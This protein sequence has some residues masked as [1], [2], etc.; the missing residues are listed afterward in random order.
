MTWPTTEALS[1][2]AGRRLPALAI[3]IVAILLGVVGLLFL[4][5]QYTKVGLA[6]RAVASNPES[7]RLVGI[8]VFLDVA[9]SAGTLP[10]DLRAVGCS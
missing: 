3:V 6:M 5:F 2:P 8:P 9:H 10:L 1:Q 7:S 4:L